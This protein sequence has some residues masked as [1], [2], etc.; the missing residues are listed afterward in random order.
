MRKVTASA[1]ILTAI[2]GCSQS[3]V[4]S[5][6]WSFEDPANQQLDTAFSGQTFSSQAFS[7]QQD[8]S[9]NLLTESF[10][11]DTEDLLSK[12][13]RTLVGSPLKQ[14]RSR[15]ATLPTRQ[16]NTLADVASLATLPNIPDP[17]ISQRVASRTDTL[18]SVRSYLSATSSAVDIRN[19]VPYSSQV[20]LPAAPV[21]SDTSAPTGELAV[22]PVPTELSPVAGVTI[23]AAQA[24]AEF[25]LTA[26]FALTDFVQGASTSFPSTTAFAPPS[27]SSGAFAPTL[28]PTE[29]RYISESYIEEGES[30]S[31][32]LAEGANE[33]SGQP[34][35]VATFQDD[36]PVLEPASI[37]TSILQTLAQNGD[38]EAL[39]TLAAA[40]TTSRTV[41]I[42]VTAT[43]RPPTLAGLLASVPQRDEAPIVTSFEVVPNS[44]PGVSQSVSPSVSSVSD[45]EILTGLA[46]E[47]LLVLGGSPVPAF[48]PS[49]VEVPT[50][51]LNVAPAEA[52]PAEAVPAEAISVEAVPAEIDLLESL[53]VE[54]LQSEATPVSSAPTLESVHHL[55]SEGLH[56]QLLEGLALAEQ[57]TA[58]LSAV[59]VP[60]PE[61]SVTDIPAAF[62]REAIAALGSNIDQQDFIAAAAS[63][64]QFS[65]LS[66]LDM[67]AEIREEAYQQGNPTAT[68]VRLD[69]PS[70]VTKRV[71]PAKYRQRIVWQ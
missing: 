27:S 63:N 37:G 54:T 3:D 41:E 43:E 59:Y 52:V 14:Y 35:Q 6:K 53:E 71:Q 45:G 56:S 8:D 18:A 46:A 55:G 39:A 65:E 62:I 26:D 24:T 47:Q 12:D 50:G 48:S 22:L 40:E 16:S 67:Q 49:A 61:A 42:A 51:L 60:I 29:E 1:V 31:S 33:G 17:E 44:S 28:T 69:G 23:D 20:Y 19:R 11:S 15:T 10:T 7:E 66:L 34:T 25:A 36:L 21:Y 2:T 57:S 38:A 13:T 68:L 64:R 58:A 32:Y 4:P 5:A 30:E 70:L 9:G